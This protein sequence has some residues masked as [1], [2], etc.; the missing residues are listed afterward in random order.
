MQHATQADIT[1]EEISKSVKRLKNNKAAGPDGI[2]AELLKHGG[3]ILVVEMTWL[4]NA[5]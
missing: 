5:I 4:F 2:P 1:Q 3:G